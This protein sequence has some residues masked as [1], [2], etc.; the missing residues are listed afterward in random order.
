MASLSTGP[1]LR[2]TV[3]LAG[4]RRPGLLLADLGVQRNW[5][6]GEGYTQGLWAGL[7]VEQTVGRDWRAGI[8]PRLWT[9]RYDEGTDAAHPRGRSLDL[10]VAR[11][12]GSGWLTLG[13]K[14]SREK[15]ERRNLRWSSRAV[16]L[17]Y[18]TSIGRDWNLSASAGLTRTTFD[19]EA[20]LFFTRRDDRTRQIGITA[21]HRQLAWE[22]YLPEL[23]LNWSRTA[24]SIPLY[25]RDVRTLRL[26]MRRL[27]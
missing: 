3:G 5:R 10:Y 18:A 6:G 4:G 17:R 2:Y 1:R 15:A 19:A 11:R 26:G 21:S 20:P 9:T 13:G 27:F 23:T 24:S 22:G 14:V 7:G 8:F 12:I 16:S 25:E